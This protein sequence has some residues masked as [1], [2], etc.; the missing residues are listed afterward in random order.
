MTLWNP[1][2]AVAAP[3]AT[4]PGGASASLFNISARNDAPP[5]VP[6]MPPAEPPRLLLVDDEPR[7]LASLAALLQHR[8]YHLATAATG[9]E[10]LRHLAEGGFD[11]VLLDLRLPDFGGHQVMDHINASDIDADVIVMSGMV[12]IEAAIGALKRGAHDYLRK[13][14]DR[15]EL[16]GTVEN[17]LRQRA[18]VQA[19]RRIARQLES[20]E[21][22][23][24]Y[25]VDASPDIIY[26]L[27]HE[28]RFAFVNDRACEL[29]GYRREEL[30]GRHYTSLVVE[31]DLERARFVFNERR[32]DE[33]A[34]RN[35]ELRLQCGPG[36][37]HERIFSNTL[38]TI[39]LSAIGIHLHG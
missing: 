15:E 31:E 26:T 11:L 32:A 14:Y 23:Y 25:L 39:S 20:S 38:M 7:A 8:G 3:D 22:M 30:V 28:G 13:P 27:N 9:A 12:E 33:R 6:W 29:L 2:T 35:V 5:G 37:S 19:N 21:Q 4:R 16:L 24:R 34:A 1:N 36:T 18:L 17:A 10:A